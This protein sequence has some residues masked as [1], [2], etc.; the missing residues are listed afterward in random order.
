MPPAYFAGGN[1]LFNLL[2]TLKEHLK[3]NRLPGRFAMEVDIVIDEDR[4]AVAD[5]AFLTKQDETRQASASHRAGSSNPNR[6]RLLVPPTLIVESISPGHEGHDLRLKKRW[7]AEFRVPHYWIIDAFQESLTCLRL[8]G[9]KYRTAAS[10]RGTEQLKTSLFPGL[11]I[12]L[13]PIWRE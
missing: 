10:G 12:P 2:F 13:E 6:T 8:D 3:Q 9:R 4:V 7:Y 5:A 1:A 11:V